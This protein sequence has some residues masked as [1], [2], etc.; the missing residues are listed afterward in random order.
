MVP[1]ESPSIFFNLTKHNL[2]PFESIFKMGI[3]HIPKPQDTTQD[4]VHAELDHYIDKICWKDHF[5]GETNEASDKSLRL[6]NVPFPVNKIPV[7]ISNTKRILQTKIDNHFKKHPTR[8][9]FDCTKQLRDYLLKNPDI[10]LVLSDKNLGLIAIET[11]KYHEL[12]MNHL[13]SNKYTLIGKNDRHLWFQP[14]ASNTRSR[15]ENILRIIQKTEHD[16]GIQRFARYYSS[17]QDWKIPKFHVLPKLHKLADPLRM[18][19]SLTSRPI[20]GAVDWYTTPVSIILSK[21]LR[22][23]VSRES[24]VAKNSFHVLLEIER[25]NLSQTTQN[26]Q[27]CIVTLDVKDLYTNID[28]NTL[29]TILDNRSGNTYLSSLMEF[30]C[31]H[32]YFEYNSHV[33]RQDNGIAM[34]TNAAPELAN[35]YLVEMLDRHV[36]NHRYVA[37]YQRYLDDVLLFWTGPKIELIMLLKQVSNKDIGLAFTLSSSR[38]KLDY[39]DICIVKNRDR[40]EHYTHQKILNKYGY[41]SRMSCHPPHTFSGFIKGELTR[42]AMNSS[43]KAFY[44][45]TKTL[46]YK[47]LLQRGYQRT[48]LNALFKSHRYS[49]KFKTAAPAKSRLITNFAIRY[50]FKPNLQKIPRSIKTFGDFFWAKRF[51]SH[52][53]RTAWRRSRNLYDVLCSSSLTTPQAEYLKQFG[54]VSTI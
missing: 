7:D 49:A 18:I 30:I 31:R 40:I 34:G 6:P 20:V 26:Q 42:Y 13:S 19:D 5:N 14:F 53:T 17:Y 33:Y 35:L 39:L 24:H 29:K 36:M 22:V 47:R 4:E 15:F 54:P 50:S 32:N 52:E 10:R 21:K 2:K 11:T 9:V 37:L 44:G 28:I 48:Y 8:K 45:V 1:L 51:G 43:N 46:F 41:I 25:F 16:E 27:F 12:V 38:T 23:M 3:K